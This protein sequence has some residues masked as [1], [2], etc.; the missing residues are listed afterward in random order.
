VPKSFGLEALDVLCSSVEAI[1]E[2]LATAWE[3][4]FPV[5]IAREGA[6][7]Y[8]VVDYRLEASP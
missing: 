6:D 2:D 3:D 4:P 1:E 8:G 7:F 5:S